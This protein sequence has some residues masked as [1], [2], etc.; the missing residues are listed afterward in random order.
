[1][2]SLDGLTWTDYTGPF[3][4]AQ[5]GIWNIAYYSYD[6]AGNREASQ[7]VT[8]LIDK[9]SPTT[10]ADI[11][12]GLGSNGWYVSEVTVVLAATDMTSGTACSEYSFDGNT[13]F[14]YSEPI[15][16]RTEGTTSL[17]YRSV[18]YAG[19]ME[20]PALMSIPIDMSPP[21]TVAV[22][23]GEV[24]NLGWYVSDVNVT[25]VGTD[26]ISG[27][28]ITYYS[29]D[30]ATWNAYVTV[31]D[32]TSEG[33][34]KLYFFSVDAAGNTEK[35]KAIDINIDMT[36]P[37]T[38]LSTE[39]YHTTGMI[40]LT[41]T[42]SMS[43]VAYTY[44][45]IG[46]DWIEYSEPFHFAAAAGMNVIDYYSVDN[47]GN[48]ELSKSTVF[49]LTE[50][51]VTS[52]VSFYP[53]PPC[54]YA[55]LDS[56]DVYFIY[57]RRAGYVLMTGS[58]LLWYN[59]DVKSELSESIPTLSIAPSLPSDFT[60]RGLTVWLVLPSGHQVLM[61]VYMNCT[62]RGGIVLYPRSYDSV[63]VSFDGHAIT[64]TNVPSGAR[65]FVSVAMEFDLTGSVWKSPGNFHVES[66]TFS[67]VVQ[68]S[69]TYYSWYTLPVVSHVAKQYPR[70]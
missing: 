36:P 67:T 33:T 29:F 14:T 30:N 18:D 42:D 20:T 5:E 19:N 52:F 69:G 8:L 57:N 32:L 23:Q 58:W 51:E 37:D 35:V 46:A 6:N 12:G 21:T 10:T 28:S 13:W 40:S 53:Y 61:Y 3:V 66:Y 68:A 56:L 62:C 1:M 39:S 25:L 9:S 44:Y 4:I 43:G 34:F 17:C 50:V 60:M 49:T 47:A 27:I 41:A 16:I 24:G 15:A 65:V 55:P 31:F 63:S 64:V 38:E 54:K 2:Y 26:P 11:Q 59:I 45:R 48:E 22:L 7:S 70:C